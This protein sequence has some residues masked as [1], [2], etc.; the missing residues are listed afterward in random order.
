MSEKTALELFSRKYGLEAPILQP[1][2]ETETDM[3]LEG[4]RTVAV[5]QG[6]ELRTVALETLFAGAVELML[7]EVNEQQLVKGYFPVLSP[8]GAWTRPC[9]ESFF[10]S[11]LKHTVRRPA[12]YLF[13]EFSTR[14]TLTAHH[15]A[16]G[17]SDERWWGVIRDE[18]T[19]SGI[20]MSVK[21]AIASR[22]GVLPQL[23]SADNY[24][25]RG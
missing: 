14:N 10:F 20:G 23:V 3:L 5:K 9:F 12:K 6:S 11:V 21:Q 16:I 17:S 2:E 22:I 4:I 19:L 18:K 8:A 15:A 25:I 24:Y 13:P 1:V 7:Q